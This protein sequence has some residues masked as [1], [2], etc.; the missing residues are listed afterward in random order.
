M[1]AIIKVGLFFTG[2]PVLIILWC[3]FFHIFL[4]LNVDPVMK[5]I[6]AYVDLAVPMLF[7]FLLVFI[8][9]GLLIVMFSEKGT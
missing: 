8:T 7:I 1:P 4:G 5:L 9:V 2:L 6:G 3:G